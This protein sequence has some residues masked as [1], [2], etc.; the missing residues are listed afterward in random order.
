MKIPL[1]I[2]SWMRV[3]IELLS[4]GVA[5]YLLLSVSYAGDR[6]FSLSFSN[7]IILVFTSLVLVCECK[8]NGNR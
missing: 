2:P 8:S 4:Y 5:I 6:K 3:L 7:I 1:K